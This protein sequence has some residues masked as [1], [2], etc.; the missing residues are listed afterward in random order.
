MHSRTKGEGYLSPKLS[1]VELLGIATV[2][3][4]HA[5]QVQVNTSSST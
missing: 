5:L 2:V 4:K 3:E 1:R